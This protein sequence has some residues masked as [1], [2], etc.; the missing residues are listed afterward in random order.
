[1]LGARF[2]SGEVPDVRTRRIIAIVVAF[3][4]LP[5]VVLGLID[6]LEGGIA[7]LAAIGLGVVAWVLSRVPVPKLAWI[8]AAATLVVGAVTLA[9]AM[10]N[11]PADPQPGPDTVMGPMRG[12]LVALNWVWRAGVLV[13]LAGAV[14]Y[15]VRLFQSLRSTEARR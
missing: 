11:I 13:T 10:A 2:P 12:A 6:P 5:L 9:I 3:A 15:V 14:L 4:A 1:M 7:L 8:A